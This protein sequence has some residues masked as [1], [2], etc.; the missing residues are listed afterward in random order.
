MEKS[1]RH[2]QLFLMCTIPVLIFSSIF[3]EPTMFSIFVFNLLPVRILLISFDL[4]LFILAFRKINFKLLF[5]DWVFI[6]LSAFILFSSISY[7]YT[8]DIRSYFSIMAFW[9]NLL[10]FYTLLFSFKEEL[11]NV[12]N[13]IEKTYFVSFIVMLVASILTFI[14]YFYRYYYK[15]YWGP[16]RVSFFIADENHYSIYILLALFV[17][18]YFLLTKKFNNKFLYTLIFLLSSIFFGLKSRSG[19]LALLISIA[20]FI[21]LYKFKIEKKRLYKLAPISI[22]FA[23]LLFGDLFFKPFT[24]TSSP[25]IYKNAPFDILTTQNDIASADSFSLSEADIK[26]FSKQTYFFDNLP[27]FLNEA[28]VK[29]HFA[30]IYSS[31][32]LGVQK[33]VFGWG[34]GSF[35]EALDNNKELKYLYARY[36]PQAANGG[37]Y[38]AHSMYGQALAETGFVGLLLYL[39]FVLAIFYKF[40]QLFL[41]AKDF[42]SKIYYLTFFSVFAGSLVFTIFYNL[43][44][45]WFW[46]PMI[47]GLFLVEKKELTS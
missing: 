23:G 3:A 4:I 1:K 11:R 27:L 41:S 36:D 9:G 35:N 30:L 43:H 42:D 46:V 40:Y 47:L 37:L 44:E 16:F 24:S 6:S 22:I 19:F 34:L 12:K 10:L 39:N 21:F 25:I 18:L 29:S 20:T 8:L 14:W 15:G 5:K 32:N 7:F 26:R 38:P 31:V 2:V 28:S 45:E 13:I 17:C 33:P